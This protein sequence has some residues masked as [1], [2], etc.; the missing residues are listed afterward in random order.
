[1]IL[2]QVGCG[3]NLINANH[4]IFKVQLNNLPKTLTMETFAQN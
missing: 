2:D 3:S 4:Q 1:M